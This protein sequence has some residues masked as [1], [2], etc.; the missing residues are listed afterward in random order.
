[1]GLHRTQDTALFEK[2]VNELAKTD[3][4]VI[5]IRADVERSGT[6]VTYDLLQELKNGDSTFFYLVP[7]SFSTATSKDRSALIKPW[8]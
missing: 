5:E 7:L 8:N 4:D 1:M 6:F 3:N 2:P